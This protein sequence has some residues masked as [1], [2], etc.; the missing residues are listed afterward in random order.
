M[1]L[2]RFHHAALALQ[3]TAVTLD[4]RVAEHIRVLR[5][6]PGHAILLFDGKG[7][8]A[9]AT[10]T[11][12]EKSA[13]ICDVFARRDEKR[14]RKIPLV[15]VQCLAKSDK[16]ESIVRMGTELGAHRFLLANATHSVLRLDDKK[17][18]AR[19]E[20]LRRIAQEAAR[21]SERADVPTV[22]APQKLH[23][24]AALAPE[25]ALRI[26][27]T[28]ETTASLDSL[29]IPADVS[30]AWIVI[31]PEGGISAEERAALQALG[32]QECSLGDTILRVETAGP[33]ALALV[34]HFLSRLG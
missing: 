26:V 6:L 12:V 2:R 27:F 25:T 19:T 16:L 22:D 13:V 1:S 17:A 8:I 5:L 24:A 11:S 21:Q 18:D 33:I 4:E 30:E 23:E 9:D 15:L 7:H 29:T 28:P 20:R 31:G 3:P 34:G 14:A 10:I 32:Y